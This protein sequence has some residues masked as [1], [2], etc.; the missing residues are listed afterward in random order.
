MRRIAKWVMVCVV[1]IGM[2]APRV[3]YACT[4]TPDY[5]KVTITKIELEEEVDLPDGLTIK[6]VGQ[7]IVI[8]NRT[9]KSVFIG[10][11]PSTPIRTL[12]AYTSV[13]LAK[14]DLYHTFF[15]DDNTPNGEIF[16]SGN[17]VIASEVALVLKHNA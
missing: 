13:T 12:E 7:S 1:I 15:N 10:D 17:P 11:Y 2:A 4:P 16:W 9:E 14:G 8:D 3:A 6:I 5:W